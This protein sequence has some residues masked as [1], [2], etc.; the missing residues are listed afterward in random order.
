MAEPVTS[1]PSLA[2]R[3]FVVSISWTALV[4][5]T[6]FF[7]LASFNRNAVEKAF[8]RRLQVF[9]KLLIADIV[10]L[11]DDPSVV[12][13]ANLGEPMFGLPQSGWYW[14]VTRTDGEKPELRQSRSLWDGAPLAFPQRN[15]QEGYLDGP[16]GQVLRGVERNVNL[17]EDGNFILLVA[18]NA[19]DIEAASRQFNLVLATALL[20]LGLGM[21]IA[22][23]LQVRIGLSPLVRMRR[24]L[25]EVRDGSS[26][27]LAGPFPR[28]IQPLA[29]EINALIDRN[30]EIVERARTHV[31]NLAHALKTPISVLM[32][33]AGTHK[34]TLAAKVGEQSRIMQQ[35]VEHHLQRARL[36]AR[37]Q[38]ISANTDVR[39]VMERLVRTMERIHQD[40]GLTVTLSMASEIQFRGEQQDLEEMTGNLIDNAC[41]WAEG[42][43]Q[44][45]VRLLVQDQPS[46]RHFFVVEIEDDGE[47]LT[48]KQ[49]ED[50]GR[51][52][53][54]L[55]ETKPGTGLGLSIVKDLAELY[56]GQVV[57]DQ[58]SLGGLKASLILP[59][60]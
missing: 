60:V 38:N 52:G 2:R 27:H 4:L 29:L 19:Q 6:T 8:D 5:L 9:S 35:Q 59:R 18:G 58:S 16:N 26:S 25:A 33:E 51:R 36:A 28:E 32:N 44:V 13:G 37:I 23:V 7:G 46:A 14:Q 30:S 12:I 10:A 43:V 24:S 15:V 3:L 40:R 55:D 49:R 48:Q 20:L 17:G 34:G 45:D 54:R 1:S 57:F 31:G 41:K 22:T 47:G 11:V 56:G 39:F 42:R 53:L 50:I 21:L